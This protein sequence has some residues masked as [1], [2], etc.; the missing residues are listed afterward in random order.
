MSKLAVCMPMYNAAAF[1]ENSIT[2]ILSQTWTDFNFYIQDDVSTDASYE[3]ASTFDDPRIRL[4]RNTKNQG[5][6]ATRNSLFDIARA[7]SHEFVAIMDA[8][9]TCSTSRFERQI[10]ELEKNQYLSFCG[11]TAVIERTGGLWPVPKT[12]AEAKV[13]CIFSNPFPTPTLMFRSS[14]IERLNARY[15]PSFT[16]CADYAFMAELLFDANVAASGIV[17]PMLNYT[18]NAASISHIDSRAGQIAKDKAVKKE[19]LV[20][21]GFSVP[22]EWLNSFHDICFYD[23]CCNEQDLEKF[24]KVAAL[25]VSANRARQ[26]VDE[27]ILLSECHQRI[28]Y[29][30]S[31]FEEGKVFEDTDKAVDGALLIGLEGFASG[32]FER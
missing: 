22:D 24:R 4:A 17:E 31:D 8:D 26:L 30:R 1:V 23:P 25:I 21:F 16:P 20:R 14:D 6:A 18:Y 15:N 10:A 27:K 5:P 7:G 32:L 2:S 3:I 11:A 29:Y 9:D 13:R 28:D 19:I 12:P